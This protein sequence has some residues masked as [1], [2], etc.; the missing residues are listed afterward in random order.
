MGQ[1]PRSIMSNTHLDHQPHYNEFIFISSSAWDMLG[2]HT[3][4][5]QFPRKC[6]TDQINVAPLRPLLITNEP[7]L[8]LHLFAVLLPT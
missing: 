8:Y 4:G 2:G 3:R 7:Q 6:H 5:L 1:G